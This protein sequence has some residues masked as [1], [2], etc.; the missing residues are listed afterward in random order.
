M[1]SNSTILAKE[2]GTHSSNSKT[3]YFKN[4]PCTE[5]L[6]TEPV[7]EDYILTVIHNYMETTNNYNDVH[8]IY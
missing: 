1:S 8:N 2:N 4:K 6:S 3:P 5:N 7:R